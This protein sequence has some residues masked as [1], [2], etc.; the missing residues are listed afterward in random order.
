MTTLSPAPIPLPVTFYP[1]AKRDHRCLWFRHLPGPLAARLAAL[2][3]GDPIELLLRR[4]GEPGS[5]TPT[6]WVRMQAGRDGR[7]TQGV[8]ITEGVAFFESLHLGADIELALIDPTRAE[9][10]ADQGAS[11]P[12]D[13]TAPSVMPLPEPVRTGDRAPLFQTYIMADYSG[14]ADLAVQRR[15]IRVAVGEAGTIEILSGSFT[16]TSLVRELVARLADLTRRGVRALVGLDHQYGIP[17]ALAEEIGLGG[18]SW[19]EALARLYAGGYGEGAAGPR[20][21][22]PRGFAA[23]FNDFLRAQG[24]PDYFWSATKRGLYGLR[25]ASNPRAATTAAGVFRLT[26]LC[27][28]IGSPATPKPLSRVGDNG[29]VG[30]QSC[31]GMGHLLEV[32]QAC[33]LQRV[34]VAV[35][36]M[37]GLDLGSSAYAGRHVFAEPYPSAKRDRAVAQTDENDARESVRFLM[38]RDGQGLLPAVCDL[39][40]LTPD[41]AHAVQFEGWI[42]SHLPWNR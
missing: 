41:E 21:G 26:E 6:C 8:R 5:N 17:V 29:S 7:S 18:L 38:E 42:L 13:R 9:P 1:A 37:D 20:W 10:V 27:R 33:E 39:A 2:S 4:A 30:G 31:L 14:A 24:R 28:G 32:L 3:P 19:R 15:S 12:D 11:P 23:A 16:R 35:W 22:H 25:H 40:R 36:P 34:P